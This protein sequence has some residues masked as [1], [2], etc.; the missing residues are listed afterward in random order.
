VSRGF[1]VDVVSLL[2]WPGSRTEVLLDAGLT[3][4]ATSA[5]EAR[6]LHGSLT[7][8]SMPDSLTVAGIIQADWIGECRR[9]LGEA[10]GTV[11]VDVQEIYERQPV[12][13]ETFELT[14]DRVD[15]E[16]MLSELVTLT[17][18]LAPLCGDDCLGP[19][20]EDFPANVE[21]DEE[22]AEPEGDPRWAALDA[23]VFDEDT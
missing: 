16:P 15:L 11:D 12:D 19:A 21:R 20:P 2:R 10:E 3:G 18:P 7:A 14:D 22:G 1:I 6:R 13:G 9:C 8:E 5:A 17:L 23:L 4:V